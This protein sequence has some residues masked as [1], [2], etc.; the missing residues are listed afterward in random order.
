M[1]N[2]L[3]LGAGTAGTIMANKMYKKLRGKEWSITVVEKEMTHYYQPGFLFVPF[4][5]YTKKEIERPTRKFLPQ[6]VKVIHSTIENIHPS[7][8]NVSLSDRKV[9]SYDILIIATGTRISPEDTPGLKGELWYKNIFDFYTPEGADALAEFFKTWK[10]GNLVI[11]VADNPIK[12]PVA[13]LE[14]AFLSDYYFTGR[15]MRDKVKI[16]YVT[17]MSGAFTKPKASKMLGS[18]LKKKN[19]NLISD[20]FV[21]EVDNANKRIID[22]GGK[23]IPFDCLVSVPLHTGDPVI[24]KSGLG[25][26]FGFAKA[27]RN[28]LQST[29]YKNVFVIG[30]AGNFPSSK[31][32]SVAHFQADMLEKNILNFI[33]DRPLTATFDGHSNCYIETGYGKGILIDFNYATEP[34]AGLY[35][36]PV[37]GPFSLLKESRLNHL[38]KL[39]F[40]WI[41]WNI[42][43]KARF[44][45]VTNHMS[46]V[47]KK[48]D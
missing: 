28:T 30:D 6:G 47:G 4:G 29:L 41:Y 24:S 36:L 17:P 3:I 2:L 33:N 10:G 46:L 1:K 20:F 15:G 13:P 38:G 35:P 45:P 18:L 39:L 19:I 11:N 43:L 42:L 26:E 22:F 23:E 5:F 34:L 27:D 44:L 7:D 40:K 12:C 8:N 37:I 48:T 14:F 31:A 16:T 32:G 25:D 9:L 21:G